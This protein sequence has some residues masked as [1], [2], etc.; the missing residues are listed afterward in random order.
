MKLIALA[1]ISG[2]ALVTAGCVVIDADSHEDW[3]TSYSSN[4]E[5][6]YSADFSDDR[7][8]VRVAA[9]GCTNKDFFDVDV[10]RKGDNTFSIELERERRDY[11]E[12]HQPNGEELVWTFS[13]LG[14]PAGATVTLRNPVGR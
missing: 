2:L 11:C 10:D 7:I 3:E 1:A 12:M 5:R 13:E 6:V 9:S 14:I 8:A 4:A